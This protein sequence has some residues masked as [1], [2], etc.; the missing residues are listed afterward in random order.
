MSNIADKI[1]PILIEIAD[2]L[3]D[4]AVFNDEFPGL[5]DP[6]SYSREA[7]KAVLYIFFDMMM[8]KS[9]EKYRRD[10]IT[11]D[12]GANRAEQVG[13]E[14][15]ELIKRHTDIDTHDLYKEDK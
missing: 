3:L 4:R 7:T 10:G 5:I 12:E 11:L 15:R 14:L 2:T 1:E 8:T 13:N 6:H 9:Y